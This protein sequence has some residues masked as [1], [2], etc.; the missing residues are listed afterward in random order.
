MRL[1]NHLLPLLAFV[2]CTCIGCGSYG[3]VSPQADQ[4]SKALYSVCNRHDQPRLDTVADQIETALISAE[5]SQREAD[6]LHTIVTTA[7][8]GDWENASRDARELMEAQVEGL[9]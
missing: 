1:R 4:Y 3:K 2:G 9:Y 8:D 6:W 7:R 5:L